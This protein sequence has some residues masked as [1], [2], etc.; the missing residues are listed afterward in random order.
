MCVATAAA[1]AAA[2]AYACFQETGGKVK[3]STTQVW[4]CAYCGTGG[5]SMRTQRCVSCGAP[6]VNNQSLISHATVYQNRPIRPRPTGYPSRT[7]RMGKDH[8][9][10]ESTSGV[11]SSRGP[12]IPESFGS[13]LISG[14]S[15]VSESHVSDYQETSQT[16]DGSLG[17]TS[18]APTSIESSSPTIQE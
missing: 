16:T 3:I 12:D 5:H 15:G 6:Y 4:S 1:V 8:S 14:Y 18:D 13:S 17:F 10:P 11:V 7:N 2:G 9:V